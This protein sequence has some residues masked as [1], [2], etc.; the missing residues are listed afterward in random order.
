MNQK[1]TPV[2]TALINYKAAGRFHMPGHKG[3]LPGAFSE[4]APLDVTELAFSDNLYMPQTILAQAQALFAEACGSKGSYMVTD[5]ASAAIAIMLGAAAGWGGKVLCTRNIHRSVTDACVLWNIQPV[6]IPSETDA[7]G[8]LL[9]LRPETAEKYF[10]E[11]PDVT[12]L[13]V[14]SP[15]YYGKTAQMEKIAEVTHAAG[16]LFL[17]DEA[18]G[19][20][21]PY[22]EGLL[23]KSAGACGGDLWVHSMHKTMGA[24]TQAALLHCNSTALKDRI[25]ALL[26]LCCTS[27]PSYP[28]MASMD[29]SRAFYASEL[30]NEAFLGKILSL[31][32]RI[33]AIQGLAL[34]P[35]NEI[36]ITRLTIDVSLR[37]GGTAADRFLAGKGIMVEM[38]DPR[39]IVLILTPY[40]RDYH[41]LVQA[42]EQL[43]FDPI[44]AKDIPLP[45]LPATR[46]CPRDAFFSQWD[47]LPLQKAKGRISAGSIGVYPPGI[48]VFCGGEEMDEAGIQYL[49]TMQEQGCA[50]FGCKSGLCAVVKDQR[51]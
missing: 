47:W 22:F 12:A 8:L 37:C 10:Q 30:N 28:I 29:L 48:P 7:N 16:K 35:Q 44:P 2:Y 34:L 36:D 13:L 32:E 23:P 15:D 46:L 18:H 5:G 4:I 24:L 19:A 26:P 3:C 6:F 27:S 51:V 9:P 14:T 42:L 33:A 39:H 11:N 45:H 38:S 31:R 41:S 21:L 20:H 40:D 50:L 1:E 49:L 43:P 25:E 17:V